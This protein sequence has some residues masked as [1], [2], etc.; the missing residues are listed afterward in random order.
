MRVSL[1]E[2]HLA[3]RHLGLWRKTTL[4]ILTGTPFLLFFLPPP[5]APHQLSSPCETFFHFYQFLIYP[6]GIVLHVKMYI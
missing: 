6:S 2:E 1:T 4:S 3:W 5:Q